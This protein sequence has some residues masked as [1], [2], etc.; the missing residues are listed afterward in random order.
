MTAGGNAQTLAAGVVCALGAGLVWGLVFVAPLML[1]DYPAAALSIGRYLAFGLIALP[2]AVLQRRSLARL[3]RADWLEALCLAL[4]GHLIYYASLAAAI[5]LAGGTL[6]TLIIG[7]LPLVISVV[8]NLGTRELPWRSL[9]LAL[10]LIAAGLLCVHLHEWGLAADALSGRS[11]DPT[12]EGLLGLSLAVLALVCWTW[13]P[14]RN[15]RW[16]R[17]R[18]VVSASAWATAQGLATLPL[19]IVAALASLAWLQSGSAPQ[20]AGYNWPL[21]P[22]PWEFMAAMLAMGLLAS[23]LGTWLWN[24]AAERLP[25]A[26]SGQL[27]V[28]ETIAALIYVFMLRGQVP[29]ATTLLGIALLLAGVLAGI[30]AVVSR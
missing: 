24:R 7:T 2:L 21:G 19:A 20:A 17:H 12:T 11:T 15:A 25:T 18:A 3:T 6:P 23:W 1:A 26:L 29:E 5:Q 4:V 16:L 22:R 14:I 13:Y 10:A 8:S 30:R 27:I 28:F 9:S